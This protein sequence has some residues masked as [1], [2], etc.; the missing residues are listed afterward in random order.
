MP[1]VMYHPA[2]DRKITVRTEAQARIHERSG[3]ERVENGEPEAAPVEQ[4]R[5]DEQSEE[6]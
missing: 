2:L 5:E 1:I 4:F 3:W 6:A